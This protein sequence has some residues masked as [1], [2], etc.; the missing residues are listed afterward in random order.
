MSHGH[1]LRLSD[2]IFFVTVN[3][4]RALAPRAASEFELVAAA[5]N[6]SRRKLSFL[7][8]G[9]V[10]MPD[11]GHAL[12][13]PTFPLTI[14]RVVQD[15]KWLSARSLNRRRQ[16]SGPVRQH[17][18]WDR[19]VRHPREFG[20]RLDYMHLNPVRKGLVKRAEEWPWSSYNNFTLDKEQ[21]ERCHM[22]IDYIHLPESYRV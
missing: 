22:Q 16:A 20:A 4:R 2:R 15:V 11:H 10:L 18:F 13:G 17:P 7:F 9:Y 8:L 5:I 3:L 6:E 14:S 12:I 1:R 19:F 21:V